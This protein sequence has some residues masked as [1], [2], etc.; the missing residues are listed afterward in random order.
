MPKKNRDSVLS[1]VGMMRSSK[2]P[3]AN[4]ALQE[5]KTLHSIF[6]R[7]QFMRHVHYKIRSKGELAGSTLFFIGTLLPKGKEWRSAPLT[8][9]ILH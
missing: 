5:P 2:M 8:E 3:L 7:R 6:Y 9:S 1:I 4:I